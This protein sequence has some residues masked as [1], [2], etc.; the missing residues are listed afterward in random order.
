MIFWENIQMVKFKLIVHNLT[1][2]NFYLTW[3][4]RDLIKSQK[5]QYGIFI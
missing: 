2:N 3:K 5:D 4:H 1:D